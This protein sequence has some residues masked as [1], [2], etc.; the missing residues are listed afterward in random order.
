MGIDWEAAIQT[1]PEAGK[2]A[3]GIIWATRA[4]VHGQSTGLEKRYSRY[5]LV[6]TLLVSTAS[7]AAAVISPIFIRMPS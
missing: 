1:I 7:I 4:S 3:V 2:R 6:P 5:E